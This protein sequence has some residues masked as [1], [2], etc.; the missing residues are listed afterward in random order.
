MEIVREP[1]NSENTVTTTT[2]ICN[3]YL[4][5]HAANQY[6]VTADRKSACR[7]LQKTDDL[8]LI[9]RAAPTGDDT[10]T[11]LGESYRQVRKKICYPKLNYLAT[12]HQRLFSFYDVLLS[13][14]ECEE[15]QTNPW[16]IL[17]AR[18]VHHIFQ[19]ST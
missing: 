12:N 13:S 11:A 9:E 5:Y 6:T 4:H 10:I 19:H 14:D 3:N 16:E 1:E 18:S 2:I 8:D 15:N 7:S 17:P